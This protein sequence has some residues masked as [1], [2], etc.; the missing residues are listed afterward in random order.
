MVLVIG[1]SVS[2]IVSTGPALAAGIICTSLALRWRNEGLSRRPIALRLAFLGMALGAA[3]AVAAGSLGEGELLV[4]SLYLGPGA[5]TGLLMGLAVP[6]ALWGAS[7][8][9]TSRFS[10]AASEDPI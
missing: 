6:R 7:R 9:P 3:A 2:Y 5:L 10:D 1:V 4:S 8:R